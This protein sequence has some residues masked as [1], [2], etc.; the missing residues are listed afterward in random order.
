MFAI[1]LSKEKQKKKWAAGFSDLPAI[2]ATVLGTWHPQI[3]R[4]SYG[5][6]LWKEKPIEAKQL[7]SRWMNQLS[8]NALS[9]DLVRS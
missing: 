3:F 6:E 2:N 5:P 7:A 9:S 8:S 4:P 1:K